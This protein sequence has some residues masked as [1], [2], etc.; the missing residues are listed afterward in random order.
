[1]FYLELQ[2]HFKKYG[3]EYEI[4]YFD[5]TWFAAHREK[6]EFMLDNDIDPDKI[7]EWC[8]FEQIFEAPFMYDQ[9]MLMAE[10]LYKKFDI[11]TG[12]LEHHLR[13]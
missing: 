5:N 11:V 7:E 1:M 8:N 10:N 13:K 12:E 4:E 2:I 6:Y 9:A 3:Y